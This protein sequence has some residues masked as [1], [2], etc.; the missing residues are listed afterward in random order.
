[1]SI[2]KPIDKK[3]MPYT[4]MLFCAFANNVNDN[5][6]EEYANFVMP[7]IIENVNYTR[8]AIYQNSNNGI[9]PLGNYT[10]VIDMKTS[11]FYRN[12]DGVKTEIEYLEPLAF[13]SKGY[14]EQTTKYFTI[15]Q[16]TSSFILGIYEKYNDGV[17]VASKNIRSTALK[18]AG[19]TW[20]SITNIDIGGFGNK[21]DIL[22]LTGNIEI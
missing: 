11:K 15:R 20:H 10:L 9:A 2:W 5:I 3:Y 19:Y 8:N 1:M 6:E 17:K 7:T 4:I 13:C 12:I 14:D 21:P 18:R 16:Q 22:T